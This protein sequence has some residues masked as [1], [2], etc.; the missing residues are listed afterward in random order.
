MEGSVERFMREERRRADY[1]VIRR[2][3]DASFGNSI[4]AARD[5]F[6]ALI[7][8]FSINRTQKEGIGYRLKPL[9]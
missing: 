6:G 9:K 7:I 1:T 5:D 8:P 2:V 4:V 3:D